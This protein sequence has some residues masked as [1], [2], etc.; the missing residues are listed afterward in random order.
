LQLI[1]TDY[2][3]NIK[4]HN[5]LPNNKLIDLAIL[6][7]ALVFYL[8][9]KTRFQVKSPFVKEFITEVLENNRT[10]YAPGKII[11]L[12]ERLRQ[13]QRIIQHTDFGAGSKLGS[14]EKSIKSFVNTSAS[15]K[16][17]GEIL[18]NLARYMDAKN[19]LELGTNV[20]LG[21]A[22][23]ASANSASCVETIE[24]CPELCQVAKE[25][26]SVIG[27]NNVNITPGKFSDQLK[28]ICAKL[29]KIDL[30]FI[31]G[32]HSYEGTLAY[33]EQIKPYLHD[34]SI[35]VFD[36]IYWSDGMTKAWNKIKS[37]SDVSLNIDVFRLGI[38]FFDKEIKKRE[39]KLVPYRYKLWRRYF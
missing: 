18:F 22:Y 7:K 32:D 16:Y 9:A 4:R 2:L 27:I 26:L 14:T 11:A 28:I 12:R 23:L 34:Q 13:D 19:I 25:A 15:S 17:K 6:R 39:L 29:K 38:I 21:T 8:Q 1:R 33:Y 24:G 5:A 35:V 10:Y 20:G 30:V 36:D 37:Q 31:D 3:W